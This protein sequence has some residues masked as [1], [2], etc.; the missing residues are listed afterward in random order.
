MMQSTENR[1]GSHAI[2][3]RKLVAMWAGRNL[4]PGRFRNA[5]PER[6]VRPTAIGIGN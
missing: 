6:G 4:S 2:A 1:R 3:R 5:R